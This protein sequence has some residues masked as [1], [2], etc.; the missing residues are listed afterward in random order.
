MLCLT[1]HLAFSS[2]LLYTSGCTPLT[3]CCQY[4]IGIWYGAHISYLIAVRFYV[5]VC[6]GG[7]SLMFAGLLLLYISIYVITVIYC[8]ICNYYLVCM[9][10][11]YVIQRSMFGSS[12]NCEIT[13]SLCE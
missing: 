12:D 6:V 10:M 5:C 4:G 1:E 7:G 8:T 13:C 2:V 9:C 3:Q 11:N